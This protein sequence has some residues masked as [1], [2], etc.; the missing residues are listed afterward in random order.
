VSDEVDGGDRV[1][2]GN[3]SQ[4]QIAAVEAEGDE[5]ESKRRYIYISAIIMFISKQCEPL[6]SM[7]A[8]LSSE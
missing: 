5:L 3:M 4:V 7:G 1:A 2:H 8:E 6:E